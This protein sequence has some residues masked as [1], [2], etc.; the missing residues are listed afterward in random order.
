MIEELAKLSNKEELAQISITRANELQDKLNAFVTIIDQPTH[1]DNKNSVINMIPY[2]TKD[3]IST[4]GILTTASSNT[5]KDY[6]PIFNATVIEKLNAA[7]AINIGKTVL[8]ELG[9]GGTGLTGHTGVVH[10]PWNINHITG[11]SSAGSA[12]AVAA[13]IVAFALGSD[14]GDSIRKPASYCGIVGYKPTYGLVSRYGLIPFASSLD[15]IGVLTRSVKDA[16]IVIDTIK[17]IDSNDMTTINSTMIDLT[18]KITEKLN[19]KKLFYIKE[20]C[21]LKLY[22]EKSDEL[23]E[24]LTKFHDTIKKIKASGITVTEVSVDQSLLDAIKPSYDCIS[25]AEATSNNANLTGIGFGPRG[26][27]S[28]YSDMIIDYRTKNFSPLIKRRFII[29]SYVLTKENQE[30]YFLNACRVRRMIVEA[31]NDLFKDYDGLILPSTV[32]VAPTIEKSNDVIKSNNI[33]LNN[34][35]VIGNF[36][37]FP[38]ISIP[39]GFINDLPIGINIT[40]KIMNDAEILNIAYHIESLFDFKGQFVKEVK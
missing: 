15:H 28:N 5:L 23:V 40:G 34:N 11:G 17:G 16:A 27:G 22:Q 32:G 20:L 12:A 37:G 13:G 18:A 21:D 1:Y 39:T 7:G 3:N 26:I 10:N 35:L 25:S 8:D 29:G 38:S 30:K 31:M 14:T 24:T 36:G 2:A 33:A 9:M 4:K 19:N 6:I